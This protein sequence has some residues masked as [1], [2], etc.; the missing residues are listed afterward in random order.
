MKLPSKLKKLAWNTCYLGQ[1]D[2]LIKPRQ[3][4]LA[5]CQEV[6]RDPGT[7]GITALLYIYYPKMIPIHEELDNPVL[8]GTPTQIAKE[9]LAYEKA[10]VEHIMFHVIPYKP[11]AIHKLE[12][13]LHIYRQLSIQ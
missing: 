12:E 7:I 10:G 13:A 2:T 9:I 11:A 4:L 6:G 8:F 3:E 1:V 5:A